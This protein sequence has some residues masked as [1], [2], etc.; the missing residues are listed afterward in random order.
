LP[1]PA[2]KSTILRQIDDVL[3]RFKQV[4]KKHLKIGQHT[5]GTWIEAPSDEEEETVTLLTH[6]I[7]RFR[8]PGTIAYGDRAIALVS[9]Q[10]LSGGSRIRSLACIL[11]A[12]R[13]DYEADRLQSFR[14]LVHADLFADLL[15]QADHLLEQGYKDAAAVTAGAVLEE[16]LRKLCSRH[17][18]PTTFTDGAGNVRPKKLDTMNADLAKSSAYGKIEQQ[19]VTAWAAIRNAVAHGEYT[20]Y[21]SEGVLL[22]IAGVRSF[23]GRHPA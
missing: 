17:T 16:H 22:M 13:S 2:D 5:D 4:E 1:V 3:T 11:T 12:L 14:E 7:E 6:A 23:I 20:K 10:S 9:E 19:S 15:E 21:T 8:P 18:V